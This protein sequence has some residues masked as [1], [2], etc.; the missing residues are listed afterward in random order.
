MTLC[1]FVTDLH[2]Q[3]HRFQTLFKHITR[4]KPDAVFIGGDMLPGGFGLNTNI[5]TFLEHEVFVPLKHLHETQPELQVFVILG[6]DDPKVY[7]PLFLQAEQQEVI[8]Y[9]HQRCVPFLQ[10]TVC[11]YSFVP[12]TPFQLKDWERYDVSRYVDPGCI[13]PVEGIRSVEIDIDHEKEQTIAHDL[14][15]LG[16]EADPQHTIYLFHTPPYK[17]NLDRTKLDGEKIDHAPLDVHTGSIAVQR[18]IQK[19]QPLLTLHGHIHETVRL[20]GQWMQQQGKT[21][22]ITGAHDGPELALIRFDPDNPLNA[23]REL[24]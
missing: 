15:Q 22:M 13:P 21:I 6:N 11:G 19:H 17:T 20:T 4:E 23:T 24:L 12:P 14:K 2:G 8:T 18:F 9:V 7:E 10:W 1:F 16:K 5:E 3:T